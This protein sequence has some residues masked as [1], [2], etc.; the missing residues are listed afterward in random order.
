[1]NK[2]VA[3][4]LCVIA[5][6]V[7]GATPKE[8][9]NII[10][11][12][13]DD[14]GWGDVGFNGNTVIKTPNLD[15]LA[16]DGVVMER[17]YSAAPL[18]SPTRAS[19]LTGRHPFRTGVFS[20]NVGMLRENM[21]TLPELLK[22][23]GYATGLFGKWHLGTLTYREKDANRGGAEHKYL[24]NPPAKHG[25]EES[26]VTESKVPTF[27]P[28][29]QPERNDGRFWDYIRE[30]EPYKPYGTAYW[31][32]DDRKVEE[33]LD[34]DDSRIIMDRALPFMERS[35]QAGKPFLGVIWF[36]AP[37]LPCVAGP[38]YAA[39][40]PDLDV[41]RRNYYGCITALD[42]QIGRLVAFLKA[43]QVY[44]NSIILFCSDNGPELKTPGSAGNFRGKKRSLYDGGI[45][46]PSIISWPA[47]LKGG[48]KFSLPCSTMDYMP[49]LL[50]IID[51][52]IPSDVA[53]D[54]ESVWP[55]LS[56]KEKHRQKPIVFCSARQAAVVE[57]G[58]KLYYTKGKYELYNLVEDPSERKDISALYPEQVEKLKQYMVEKIEDYR[59]SFEKG[60]KGAS[61]YW[62]E[63]WNVWE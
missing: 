35:I 8:Q 37:H 5:P 63:W 27:D 36:H 56:G 25:F 59:V 46:V 51:V 43:R 49:T 4:G 38:E 55:Q 58:F 48:E 31:N 29:I 9:P 32:Q 34:G 14:M 50:D 40:Y 21:I 7:F 28:M 62:Q 11:I 23:N 54:G 41:E 17:F 18:S 3:C 15:A 52:S 47:S 6:S 44:G 10:V 30:G 20:A 42:E 45:R 24:Y 2:I 61:Y 13:V 26:F 39:L 53:L 33:N 19:V 12:M 16:S 1:M 57:G 60:K 22:E